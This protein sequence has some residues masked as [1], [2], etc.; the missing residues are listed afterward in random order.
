MKVTIIGAGA[1]GSSCA[2]NIVRKE[3]CKEVVIIDTKKGLAKGKSLDLIQS[4]SLLGFETKIISTVSDYSLTK[5]TDVALIT[6]GNPRTPGMTREE[7]IT[8]NTKIVKDVVKNILR[9]SP[10]CIFVIVSNPM[11]TMTYL[12]LRLTKLPKNKIIGMGGALDS[13]RLKTYIALEMGISQSDL[14]ANVIGGHGDTTMIP[15]TRLATWQNIL[16]SKFLSKQTLEKISYNTMQGGAI[17]TQLLG[18]SAWY[19]PGAASMTV[20]KSI[21]LDEKKIIPCSVY[22]EGEYGEFDICLGVPVVLGKNGWE[23]IVDLDLNEEEKLLFS[24][25]ANFIRKMNNTLEFV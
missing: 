25:S 13:L 20:V 12:A 2:D 7:L 11:D 24:K 21:L 10:N 9:Y 18:T 1:V 15:L 5:N 8:I 23:K 16:V 14:Q 3:I 22:L 6:S 4:S 17:L 19:A